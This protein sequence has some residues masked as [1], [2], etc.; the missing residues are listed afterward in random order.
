VRG[1]PRTDAN[2]S[3]IIR[4]NEAQR[5]EAKRLGDGIVNAGILLLL[6]RSM[7]ATHSQVAPRQAHHALRCTL[8]T[9]QD[10]EP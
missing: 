1:R 3:I 2:V 5:D 4:V 10:D 9:L 8:Q 6:D 7:A